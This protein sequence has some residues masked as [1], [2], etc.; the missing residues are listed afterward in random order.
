MKEENR[1]PDERSSTVELQAHAEGP[2]FAEPENPV[3][4]LSP[5]IIKAVPRSSG[6]HVTCRRVSGNHYRCNWWRAVHS[7]DGNHAMTG[8]LVT[9]HRVARS[10][11][12]HVTVVDNRLQIVM[13]I[14]L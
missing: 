11:F 14:P 12:L 9:T 3:V 8:L 4:D 6:E 13:D 5:A 2:A 1:K 10:R 7:A